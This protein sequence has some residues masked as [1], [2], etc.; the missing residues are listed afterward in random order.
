MVKIYDQAIHRR[1]INEYEIYE[2]MLRG[3]SNSLL[4][5]RNAKQK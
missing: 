4:I 3:C 5:Q 2:D 1:N